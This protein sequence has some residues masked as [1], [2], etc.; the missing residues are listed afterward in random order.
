MRFGPAHC[1]PAVQYFL[2]GS[3]E[4]RRNVVI[5]TIAITKTEIDVLRVPGGTRLAQPALLNKIVGGSVVDEK[6]RH[7]SAMTGCWCCVLGHV[8]PRQPL[9]WKRE[10]NPNTTSRIGNWFRDRANADAQEM[11]S[12]SFFPKRRHAWRR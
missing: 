4:L 6:N 11:R 3:R 7:F 8:I 2:R 5:E 12:S 9:P 10:A 1:A